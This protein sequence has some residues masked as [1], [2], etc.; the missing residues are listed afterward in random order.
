MSKLT[1]NQKKYIVEYLD[2][3]NGGCFSD[4]VNS[5]IAPNY[6]EDTINFTSSAQLLNYFIDKG[7][8]A[9]ENGLLTYD[10]LLGK[11]SLK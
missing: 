3:Y 9:V 11:E 7:I 2:K 8:E 6:E 4:E 1:D 5:I 10:Q